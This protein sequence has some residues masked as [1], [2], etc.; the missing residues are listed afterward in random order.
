MKGWPSKGS[1]SGFRSPLM[2]NSLRAENQLPKIDETLTGQGNDH[3]TEW[4][5]QPFSEAI[6][7]LND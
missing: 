6:A 5:F 1:R 4:V 2:L 7:Q 3:T